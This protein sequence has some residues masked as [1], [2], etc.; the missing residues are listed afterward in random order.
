MQ[1]CKFQSWD[2]Q[3]LENFSKAGI[4]ILKTKSKEYHNIDMKNTE[5]RN[6][7][8]HLYIKKGLLLEQSQIFE[9]LYLQ[10]VVGM[11]EHFHTY[12]KSMYN[13]FKNMS[14]KLIKV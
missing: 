14:K 9:K 3:E 10:T 2:E 1:H 5:E 13:Y 11:L 12:D 8:I 7:Q 4:K 6:N